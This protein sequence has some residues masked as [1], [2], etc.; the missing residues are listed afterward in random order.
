MLN[1]LLAP[2]QPFLEVSPY[3]NP[4]ILRKAFYVFVYVIVE[5]F[6]HYVILHPSLT[7][8]AANAQN[9]LF[10]HWIGKFGILETF[11]ID[12]GNE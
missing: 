9:V 11:V 5:A 12:N 1:H 7:N 6:T 4:R 8:D 2:K 10:D 3:F